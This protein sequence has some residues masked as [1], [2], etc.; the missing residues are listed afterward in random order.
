MKLPEEL[1][2]EMLWAQ[3]KLPGLASKTVAE[4]CANIALRLV[5]DYKLKIEYLESVIEHLED[6]IDSLEY[7]ENL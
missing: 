1:V 5:E 4:D 7:G 3:R 2:S 6:K